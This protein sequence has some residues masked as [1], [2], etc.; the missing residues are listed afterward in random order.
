MNFDKNSISKLLSMSDAELEA[1][2]TEIAS[3]AGIKDQIKI[4][5]RDLAKVRAFLSI[6]TEED[7]AKL[8]QGLGG[9][10]K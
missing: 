2:I 4:G 8:I 3:E 9:K 6:A 1:V 5:K 7:V 10:K